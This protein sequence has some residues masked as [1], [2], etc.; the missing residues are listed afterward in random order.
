M[1]QASHLTLKTEVSER[2]QGGCALLEACSYSF[3][4]GGRRGA[5]SA[6]TR[7]P[8]GTRKRG[9]P[10]LL[11]I[12]HTPPHTQLG[13]LGWGLIFLFLFWVSP[14]HG[15]LWSEG[16]S[17]KCLQ[18]R[19]SLWGGPSGE[20]AGASGVL[21]E[22]CRPGQAGHYQCLSETWEFSTRRDTAHQA[23]VLLSD[24]VSPLLTLTVTQ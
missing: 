23:L 10:R 2:Q 9:P 1:K 24:S 19:F 4:G 5:G 7:L 11:T 3:G 17:P 6:F 16:L 18:S 21:S 22:M 13:W 8:V 12:N 15:K 20:D 14:R